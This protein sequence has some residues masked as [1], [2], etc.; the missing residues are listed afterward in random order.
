MRFDLQTLFVSALAVT[1]VSSTPIDEPSMVERCATTCSQHCSP[2]PATLEQQRE[3]FAKFVATA[4]GQRDF[5]RA[6]KTFA[7]DDIIQHNPAI[8]SGLQNT[9]DFFNS[10]PNLASTKYTI[11]NTNFG[12]NHIGYFHY[13]ADIAPG[14]EPFAV[15]DFYRFNGTCIQE[16]WDVVQQYDPNS[17]NPLALF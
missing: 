11:I 1:T 9:L 5:Y 14:E 17:P 6:Y 10:Q 7:A 13:R 4:I 3:I 16:H 2:R 15:V 12:D 8:M